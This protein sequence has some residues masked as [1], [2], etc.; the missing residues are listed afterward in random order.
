MK[1]MQETFAK[2]QDEINFTRQIA[3][4]KMH[5]TSHE[6]FSTGQDT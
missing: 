5:E 4:N 3:C 6:T 2:I 1:Q